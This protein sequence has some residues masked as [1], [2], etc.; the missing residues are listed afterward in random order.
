M[1]DTFKAKVLVV[2]DDPQLLSL[3]VDT[4]TAIGYSAVGAPGGLD[5]L[6]ILKDHKFDLLV[7]DIKMPNL[8]GIQLLKRVRRFYSEL[9][10]LFITGVATPDII[11]RAAPDGFLAKPFR[12]THI[13]EMIE[14]TLRAKRNRAKGPIRKVL[15][16]ES[17]DTFRTTV[18]EALNY[19]D[20]IPFSA[21]GTAEAVRELESGS[22][23]A[24]LAEASLSKLN[25]HSLAE[26]I[27]ER[28]SETPLIL[29]SA[30]ST[31]EE[32]SDGHYARFIRKP[33]PASALFRLLEEISLVPDSL[34]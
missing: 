33:F 3:L 28:F 10:V 31:V 9:P 18:T 4:L 30:D 22:F 25:G 15:V 14:R 19:G 7:T 29:M 23:D 13:E 21:S 16:V 26:I 32:L 27:H 34:A 20:Y 17:D 5:A 1:G 12:I 11:N 24:V 6:Q 2:D 8:D